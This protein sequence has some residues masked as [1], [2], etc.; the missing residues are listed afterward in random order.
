MTY[1]FFGIKK[2]IYGI[3]GLIDKNGQFVVDEVSIIVAVNPNTLIRGYSIGDALGEQL[4]SSRLA[5]TLKK[6]MQKLISRV[7]NE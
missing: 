3:V 7:F 4:E 5:P 1:Y 2:E 6:A